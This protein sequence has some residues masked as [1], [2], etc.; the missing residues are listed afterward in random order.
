MA[1]FP[2]SEYPE[3]ARGISGLD[4]RIENAVEGWIR[5]RGKKVSYRLC[6]KII[7][8]PIGWHHWLGDTVVH[9]P[10]KLGPPEA[11]SITAVEN[12]ASLVYN[13]LKCLQV[14]QDERL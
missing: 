12:T 2:A 6:R 10:P 4:G 11:A 5:C 7:K 14:E 1:L 8:F 9:G 13:S 3:R